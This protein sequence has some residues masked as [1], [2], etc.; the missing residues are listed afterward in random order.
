MSARA[1]QLCGKPLSRIRVG[2]DGDFCS[3]EHRNQYR[4][5]QGMDRLQE[6]NKV[7]SVMRRR[8]NLRPLANTTSGGSAISRREFPPAKFT[9]QA[10]QRIKSFSFAVQL[11]SA[12]VAS[13]TDKF[14]RSKP[15]QRS[16]NSR[17]RQAAAVKFTSKRRPSL[18]GSYLLTARMR[19]ERAPLAALTNRVSAK[20]PAKREYGIARPGAGRKPLDVRVKARNDIGHRTAAAFTPR[21]GPLPQANRGNALRVSAA[22]GFRLPPRRVPRIAIASDAKP[23]LHWQEEPHSTATAT[24]PAGCERRTERVAIPLWNVYCPPPPSPPGSGAFAR[25]CPVDLPSSRIRPGAPGAART[26]SIAFS[27]ASFPAMFPE[28]P[29]HR[30]IRH[31]QA[32]SHIPLQSSPAKGRGQSQSALAPFVPQDVPCAYSFTVNLNGSKDQKR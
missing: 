22:C 9:A 28:P 11:P 31:A 17:P 25:S 24:L 8:E 26:G 16:S 10:S 4:L 18:P 21:R 29:R 5:R 23:Q 3:R 6:A 19:V 13:R 30:W 20:P 1:C 7:A 14:L 12:V 15:R 2:A 32:Q 27:S